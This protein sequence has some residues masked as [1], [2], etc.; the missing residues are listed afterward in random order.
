VK[1]LK[2]ESNSGKRLRKG[3]GLAIETLRKPCETD[4]HQCISGK[5]RELV[6]KNARFT[7]TGLGKSEKDKAA[8]LCSFGGGRLSVTNEASYEEEKGENRGGKREEIYV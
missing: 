2:S 6:N 8:A 4:C 1:R 5:K 3:G 7:T